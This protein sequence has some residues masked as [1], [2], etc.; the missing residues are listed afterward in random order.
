LILQEVTVIQ[1]EEELVWLVSDLVHEILHHVC[2]DRFSIRRLR[3]L[4]AVHLAY[5]DGWIDD[6]EC[7]DQVTKKLTGVIITIVN[8]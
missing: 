8:G 7:A 2:I 4:D 3:S 5:S 1:R 6:L